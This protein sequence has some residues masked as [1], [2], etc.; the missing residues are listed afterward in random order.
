[1]HITIIMMKI[2][3]LMYIDGIGSDSLAIKGQNKEANVDNEKLNS[4]LIDINLASIKVFWRIIIE[5][6]K[7]PMK[8]ANM[9]YRICYVVGSISE[10][11]ITRF[12]AKIDTSAKIITLRIETNLIK[13]PDVKHPSASQTENKAVSNN[14]SPSNS[15]EP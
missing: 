9:R 7:K 4:Q 2:R 6:N 3:A 10:N 12:K 11:L 15:L 1:M 8:Y 5:L 14:G 13:I